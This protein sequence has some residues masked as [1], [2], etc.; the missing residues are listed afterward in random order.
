MQSRIQNSELPMALFLPSFYDGRPFVP[1]LK[2]Q[3]KI[4]LD[5]RVY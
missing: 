4:V 3:V 2:A 5:F 1:Y